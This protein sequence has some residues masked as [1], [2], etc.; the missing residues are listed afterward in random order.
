MNRTEIIM[1]ELNKF[2][3]TFSEAEIDEMFKAIM[4]KYN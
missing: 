3:G 2:R 1:A 4:A